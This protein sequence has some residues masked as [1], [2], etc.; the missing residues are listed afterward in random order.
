MNNPEFRELAQEIDLFLYS[1]DGERITDYLK[2]HEKR[3][4]LFRSTDLGVYRCYGLMYAGF[5]CWADADVEPDAD[6]ALR[7]LDAE[8]FVAR[9]FKETGDNSA[10]SL[11]EAIRQGY[12]RLCEEDENP[13][14]TGLVLGI[15]VFLAVFIFLGLKITG[16]L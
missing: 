16:H 15:I 5:A 12:R 6:P 13:P 9:W 10:A 1:A 8:S 14:L 7:S 2:F 11:V 4:V 3:I